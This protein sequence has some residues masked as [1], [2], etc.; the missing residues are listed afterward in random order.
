MESQGT[1]DLKVCKG[2]QVS[3][4]VRENADLAANQEKM[5]HLGLW[6]YR[7]HQEIEEKMA[8]PETRV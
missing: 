8:I 5:A 3:K 4:E 6:D 7:E 2:C 1:R